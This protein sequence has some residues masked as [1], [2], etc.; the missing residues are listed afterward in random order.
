MAG[1]WKFI[2]SDPNRDN[3]YLMQILS[4]YDKEHIQYALELEQLL[5]L[6]E[7]AMHSSDDPKTIVLE[8]MKTACE[9]YQA[10]WCGFL[11]VDLDLNIWAPLVWY[12]P[13]PNDKTTDVIN[14]YE[15]V[16]FMPRWIQAMKEDNPVI[17]RDIDTI[18]EQNA[19]EY[20]LFCRMNVNSLIAVPITPRPCGFLVI[21]NPKRYPKKSSMLRMLGVVILSNINQ[22]RFLE[23]A[24]KRYSPT[25][26]RNDKDIVMN[27]FGKL[28]IFTST[29]MMEEDEFNAPKIC[30]VVTF[31]LFNPGAHTPWEIAAAL[32][33]NDESSREAISSNIRGLLY[34][35]HNKFSM[36]SNY[37]LVESVYG[38]YRI[39]PEL[40]ITTDLE[41]FD[42]CMEA[43]QSAGNTMMRIEFLKQAVN[44]YR[45][46]VFASAR[47][48]F[49]ISDTVSEYHM[50]YIGIVNELL[51][52]LAENNDVA[53]VHKYA[54]IALKLEPGN[55]TAHYWKIYSLYLSG[56]V[57]M[58]KSEVNHA[59]E[60]LTDEEYE[61]LI[62]QLKKLKG[63]STFSLKLKKSFPQ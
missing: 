35:F 56:A 14:E 15:S 54:R 4:K 16:E 31:L 33:P 12:N 27:F 13:N 24:R 25:A 45:G 19:Y 48:E 40:H 49:W 18:Q 52:C 1:K 37:R 10:D 8:A 43:I 55:V 47:D 5:S 30:R 39:N 17:I 3:D 20:E 58:A 61:E 21:R 34:R 36:I 28:E 63:K 62:T 46:P 51:S 42:N 60:V 6:L 11:E 29:G 44:I 7:E 2:P 38:G 22:H 26:I 9:F 50:Q 41:Q 59:K 53:N 32:W 23:S 57:Q